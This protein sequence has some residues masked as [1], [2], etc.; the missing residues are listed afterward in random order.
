MQAPKVDYQPPPQ[1]KKR[2]AVIG[3][4]AQIDPEAL[5]AKEA[6][7]KEEARA[8]QQAQQRQ[9]WILSFQERVHVVT[10]TAQ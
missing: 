9:V 3:S 10:R 6:K 2:G 5:K 8:K 4:A 7:A 1:A